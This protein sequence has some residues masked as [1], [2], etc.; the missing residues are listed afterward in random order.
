MRELEGKAR[1]SGTFWG[2]SNRDRWGLHRGR[3]EGGHEKE[4]EDLDKGGQEA[5]C[6][7]IAE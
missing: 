6:R 2:R 5:G 4:R 1:T 7:A 3:V